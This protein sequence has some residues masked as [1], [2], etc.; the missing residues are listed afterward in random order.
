MPRKQRTIKKEFFI[1]I[2]LV[3]I[4]SFIRFYNLGKRPFWEDEALYAIISN[5]LSKNFFSDNYNPIYKG[6]LLSYPHL[7]FYFLNVRD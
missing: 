4:G 3:L 7:Y 5:Y 1:L 2:F 6:R